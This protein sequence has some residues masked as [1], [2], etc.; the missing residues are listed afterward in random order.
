MYDDSMIDDKKA[1]E[2]VCE[3]VGKITA[4]HLEEFPLVAEKLNLIRNRLN[5]VF[6]IKESIDAGKNSTNSD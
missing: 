5:F 2:R 4:Q 6:A 1:I 3:I